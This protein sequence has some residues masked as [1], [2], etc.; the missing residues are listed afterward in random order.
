MK[1]KIKE[2][3]F[4]LDEMKTMLDRDTPYKEILNNI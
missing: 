1:L 3:T 2:I 4:V